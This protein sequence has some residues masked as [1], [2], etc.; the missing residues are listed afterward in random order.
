[1]LENDLLEN[2]DRWQFYDDEET[3]VMIEI[4]K[5]VTEI[6]V[7]EMAVE[8]YTMQHNM[9]ASEAKQLIGSLNFTG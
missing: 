8:F 4:T 7:Y 2:E 9:E 1:M 6:I 5:Y 3:E